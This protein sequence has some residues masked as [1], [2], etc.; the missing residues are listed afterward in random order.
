MDDAA[1]NAAVINTRNPTWLWEYVLDAVETLLVEPE[2]MRRA[3]E[4]WH[5]ETLAG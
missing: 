3:S 5:A 4:C 2:Q 1:E